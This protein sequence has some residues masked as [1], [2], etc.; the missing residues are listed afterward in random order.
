MLESDD[1][2]VELYVLEN[3]PEQYLDL[4]YGGALYNFGKIS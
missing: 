3:C 1:P 4:M 2:F